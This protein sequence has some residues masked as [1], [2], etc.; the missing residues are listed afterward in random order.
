MRRRIRIFAVIFALFLCPTS[1]FSF[2]G[3]LQVKNQF[4]LFFHLDAPVIESAVTESSVSL[5]LS[6][7]STF[8]MKDSAEW[9]VHLDLEMTELRM[10]YRKE[11]GAI[12][13]V[14]V[15]VP[16]MSFDSGFMD[17]PL[18]SYHNAFGF[19]DYGRSTRPKNEFLYEV[20]RNGSIVARAGDG[21]VGLGDIRLSIKKEI[22]KGDPVLSLKADLELPTGSASK[23]FGS[24]SIDGGVGLLAEKRLG[25]KFNAY[26]NL[27]VVF[28]GDLKAVDTIGM[29]DYFYAG[30]AIEAAMWRHFGLIGE[31]LFQTSPFPHTDIGS[32]DRVCALVVLGGRYSSG[33]DSMEFSLTEDAN[34]AGAPDVIFN[35]TYKRRF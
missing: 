1:G 17:G 11:V 20:K 10:K 34:T 8:M 28:P 9:S 18:E 26:A 23:G 15:E 35:L 6:H 5:G 32:V 31:V 3:P 27:G 19:S 21:S 24:G 4:P 7:S 16:V 29:K 2:E 25:E 30:A 13:E 14:S 22:L 33:K 12:G